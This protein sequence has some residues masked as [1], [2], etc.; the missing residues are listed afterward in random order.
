M[1]DGQRGRVRSGSSSGI[2][3]DTSSEPTLHGA[4]GPGG[5]TPTPQGGPDLSDILPKK[6]V[7][8]LMPISGVPGRGVKS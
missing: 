8:D 1:Q 7:V 2:A 4:G 3:D 6:V 5:G